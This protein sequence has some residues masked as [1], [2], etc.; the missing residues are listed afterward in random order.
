MRP[1]ETT[2]WEG[3]HTTAAAC[4]LADL[5]RLQ[6]RFGRR[7]EIM[8]TADGGIRVFPT[9]ASDLQELEKLMTPSVTMVRRTIIF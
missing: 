8:H 9:E 5:D 3:T 2:A 6:K 7:L 4:K 1:N